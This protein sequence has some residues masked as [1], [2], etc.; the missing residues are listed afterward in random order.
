[1]AYVGRSG[2][3]TNDEFKWDHR[4]CLYFLCK[5]W[6][7]TMKI[8]A[9]V[10]RWYLSSPR[11]EDNASCTRQSFPA[12]F[13]KKR[14][15]SM[16]DGPSS[17]VET[18]PQKRRTRRAKV[19]LWGIRIFGMHVATRDQILQLRFWDSHRVVL[20]PQ[21]GLFEGGQAYLKW[22]MGTVC[23]STFISTMGSWQDLI[24]QQRFLLKEIIQ[25][26]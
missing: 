3:T 7:L 1:M 14:A 21:I 12:M 8:S 20:T 18:D 5:T 2:A 16:W 19:H 24:M 11:Y 22:A 6:L 26:E 10:D 15:A 23:S 4:S 17:R 9:S 13:M 25:L